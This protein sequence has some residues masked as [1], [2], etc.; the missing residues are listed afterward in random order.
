MANVL[1]ILLLLLIVVIL[2]FAP[3]LR[4]MLNLGGLPVEAILLMVAVS[5]TIGQL[6]G[7]PPP[8]PALYPCHRLHCAQ[9]RARPVYRR[10]K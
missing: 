8:G 5:L 3:D 7:G 2:V 9:C 1:F 6:L 4:A 10:I